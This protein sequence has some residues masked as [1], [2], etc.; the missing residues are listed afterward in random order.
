MWELSNEKYLPQLDAVEKEE[1]ESE[2]VPRGKKVAATKK[3]TK[4]VR[5][6]RQKLIFVIPYLWIAL[7]PFFSLGSHF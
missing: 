3:G 2:G 6:G 4:K 1:L 5:K 7:M